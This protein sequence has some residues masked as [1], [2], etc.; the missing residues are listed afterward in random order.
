M[1]DL[2]D[3]SDA[4]RV[5]MGTVGEFIRGRRFTK[6]DQVKEGVPSIHYGEIYTTYGISATEA[7]SHVREDLKSQLRFAR[8]GDV[9]IAAVGETVEDVGRGVAWLGST[10]VAIH[11]DCFLFRSSVLDPKFV[12]YY[13]RTEGLIREKD[14]YVAR[15]KVKRISGENLGR[16]LIPVP[17]LVEQRSIVATLDQ[18]D[19][20]LADLS[21]ALNAELQ[22]RQKQFEH[23]RNRMFDASEAGR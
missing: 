20:L 15:A 21:T 16:L 11:D 13:L 7:V 8:P 2:T 23:Y 18:Y 3:V 17:D 6:N 12:A 19:A 1:T 10:D 14:K 9:V 5:P 22:A 4:P